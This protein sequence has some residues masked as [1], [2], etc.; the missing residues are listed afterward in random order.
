M[1][2]IVLRGLFILMSTTV[3]GLYAVRAFPQSGTGQLIAIFTALGISILIVAIDIATPAKKLS[4]ISGV[5]LGLIVGMLSAYALSFLVD[6]VGTVATNVDQAKLEGTKVFLGVICIFVAISLIL[7]TKDDFRFVIPY[8]ELAK[9]IR[10]NRPLLL[11]TSAI[12]DGR[13]DE[14]AGTKILQGLVIIPRFVLNELQTISDSDDKLKRARGRR[15]LDIVGKLQSNTILDISIEDADAEGANVDQKLVAL[16]QNLHAQVITTDYNLQKVA[17]VRGVDVIN[18]NQLA[19]ALRPVVLPGELMSVKIVKPG[20]AN[21]QGVGFLEDGTMV[22]VENA[23][24]R[25]G[26]DTPL[27]VTNSLQT[28][29]GRMIFGRLPNDESPPAPSP[30]TQNTPTD[31]TPTPPAPA[32]N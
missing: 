25:I 11:D 8:V 16:A 15:G 2:H 20:E 7:Q 21:N 17:N 4:A 26:Q 9:Q 23:K 24:D 5:F 31:D 27:T 32:S 30:S 14:I 29:A 28:P 18:I 12:I 3:G 6:Y 10:G 13:I 19:D 22:V 1:I